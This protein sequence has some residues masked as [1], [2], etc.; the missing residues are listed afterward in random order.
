MKTSLINIEGIEF[1][2]Y[3]DAAQIV[4]IKNHPHYWG[5]KCKIVRTIPASSEIILTTREDMLALLGH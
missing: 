2:I 3:V 1:C 5:Q 4:I